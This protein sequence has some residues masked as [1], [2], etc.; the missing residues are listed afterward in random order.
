MRLSF[1]LLAMQHLH[2]EAD[3]VH[4]GFHGRDLLFNFVLLLSEHGQVLI[5]S[6]ISLNDQIRELF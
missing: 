4:V 3:H 2:L 6:A 1:L 5:D